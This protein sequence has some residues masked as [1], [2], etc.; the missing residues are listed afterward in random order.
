[1]KKF[2]GGLLALGLLAQ[3]VAHAEPKL[4]PTGPAEDAAFVRFVNALDGPLEV[5][6]GKDAR[7]ELTAESSTR[8]QAVKA[9]TP[10]EATLGFGGKNE[11]VS[12][13]VQ[14]SE[15]VTVAAIPEGAAGWKVELGRES[16]TD[17]SAFKVS[18]GLLNLAADCPSAT[19]KLT[20]KDVAIVEDVAPRTIKRRQ[21]NPVA[22]SVELYC[23]GKRTGTPIDLGSLRAGE[24]WTLL[25]RPTREGTRIMPILD[26]MP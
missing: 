6:A 17:F 5:R 21:I 1:M 20:G 13:S 16:P 4:Y 11:A 18:L 24:R 22:L 2:L 7:I 3:L 15:F 25:A 14:P 26:R 23:Q 19:L 8:W 12:V 10:L 9:R